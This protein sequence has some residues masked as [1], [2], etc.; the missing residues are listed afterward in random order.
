M[1]PQLFLLLLLIGKTV[2]GQGVE[3]QTNINQLGATNDPTQ[4]VRQFDNRYQ[5]IKGSPLFWD[6]YVSGVLKFKDGRIYR[7]KSL[8]YDLV[9]DSFIYKL[10]SDNRVLVLKNAETFKADSSLCPEDFCFFKRFDFSNSE[11]PSGY[12][13]VLAEGRNFFLCKISK[14]ILK[15]DF[16]G[17]YSANQNMDRFIEERRFYIVDPD[18]KISLF[19]NSQKSVTELFPLNKN[20]IKD[21][22]SKNNYK[23]KNPRDLISLLESIKNL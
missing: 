19:K 13:A 15:A 14:T 8:N 23:L 17:A 2:F 10:E 4:M 22:I 11:A 16:K 6:G 3:S 7:V 18:G 9:D 20:L 12:F 5:G 1:K 21:L